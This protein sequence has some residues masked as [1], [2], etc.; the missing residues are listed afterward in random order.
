MQ[1]K[2][3][4]SRKRRLLFL[5]SGNSC[6]SQMA[7]GWTRHLHGMRLEPYSAGVRRL[8]LNKNAV[9]AMA[10]I[11]IDISRQVSKSVQELPVR[12]F[13]LVVTLSDDAYVTCPV[14]PGRT[15]ILHNGFE[16]PRWLSALELNP[17][18]ILD[19]YR[20]IRDE[21]GAFVQE[22]PTPET[23]MLRAQGA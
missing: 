11:G 8:G 22:L 21:I 3:T 17:K 23:T 15:Q 2:T 19:H 4:M 18:K 6:C 9:R 7:E 1:P 10:E 16:D 5:C 12:E 13:D 14:F 20:R